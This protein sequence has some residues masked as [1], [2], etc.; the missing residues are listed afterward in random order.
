MIGQLRRDIVQLQSHL[1]EAM[2]YMKQGSADESVDRQVL[3][4]VLICVR[5]LVSNLIIGF[6]TTKHGDPKRFEILGLMGTILKLSDDEKV[7]VGLIRQPGVTTTSPRSSSTTNGQISPAEVHLL[8]F[9]P[10]LCVEFHG[11]VDYIS[12]NR[13]IF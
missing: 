6:L 11:H 3:I 5:R 13:D 7:K 2:R 10:T 4:I 8:F 12:S 1:N 9:K